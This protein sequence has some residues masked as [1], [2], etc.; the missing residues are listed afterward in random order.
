MADDTIALLRQVGIGNADFFGYSMGA[1]IALQVTL[2][3]PDPVRR[4]VFASSAL[5]LT[6]SIPDSSRGYRT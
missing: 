2:Q 5:T 6:G 1:D 3:Q 4:L